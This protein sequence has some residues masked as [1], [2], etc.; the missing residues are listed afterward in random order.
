MDEQVKYKKLTIKS[1][2]FLKRGCI[3]Y[4]EKL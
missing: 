2:N 3:N 1:V 4:D